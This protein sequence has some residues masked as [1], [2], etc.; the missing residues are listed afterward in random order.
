MEA[1]PHGE[2]ERGE[3]LSQMYAEDQDG[4]QGIGEIIG[5]VDS[6]PDKESEDP[7]EKGKTK[8]RGI[9]GWET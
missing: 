5:G 1:G 2:S 7:R 3:Y 8:E 4:L 6:G 9:K